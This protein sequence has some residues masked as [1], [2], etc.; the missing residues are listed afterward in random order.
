MSIPN[1]RYSKTTLFIMYGHLEDFNID[2]LFIK[3]THSG[4]TEILSY[5]LG[6]LSREVC[7]LGRLPINVV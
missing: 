6:S 1:S 3:R 5:C 7:Y 2:M 4:E